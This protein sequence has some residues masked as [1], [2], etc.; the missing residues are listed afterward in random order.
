MLALDE[1]LAEQVHD[2]P[3]NVFVRVE[4]R[5][6]GEP[7]LLRHR[8]GRRLLH[9][10]FEGLKGLRVHFAQPAGEAAEARRLVLYISHAM[11][12]LAHAYDKVGVVPRR[13]THAAGWEGWQE[14]GA[15]LPLLEELKGG[16]HSL[17]HSGLVDDALA[18]GVARRWLPLEQKGTIEVRPSL[19]R[20]G[21]R[22]YLCP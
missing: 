17:G 8:E 15:G 18:V 10:S 6:E 11:A 14:A 21:N 2:D 19:R 20:P 12:V 9:E 5:G 7:R 16:A 1:K 4:G 22:N 3:R 13:S